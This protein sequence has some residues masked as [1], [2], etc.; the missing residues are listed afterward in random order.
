M[1][2][3]K[4]AHRRRRPPAA[5]RRAHAGRDPRRGHPR[6]RAAR[7]GRRARRPHRGARRRPTSGC[8]ITTSAPRTT[9]FLAVLE[10][11]YEHIR[12]E[13]QRLHL[14]DLPPARAVA[15]AGGVHLELFPGAPGVHD[16][17][18]RRESA[19]RAAPQAL[20]QD[21]GDAF[22]AGGHPLGDPAGAACAQARSAAASIRCSSTSRSPRSAY[23][24]LSNHHTLSTIF[25]RDLMA[26]P[27]KAERLAHMQALVRGFL[28]AC[29]A[30]AAAC[31]RAPD[32]SILINQPV[33]RAAVRARAREPPPRTRPPPSPAP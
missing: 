28:A 32:A 14:A 11:A 24:Y 19:P 15:R 3:P 12:G 33:N 29:G 20:A 26:A 17:A 6:V 5:R 13:E 10:R 22:A 23:F 16:A 9:L 21:P 27:A 2:A 30:A 4:Q 31:A 1:A 18:E 7:P 25:G 8:S